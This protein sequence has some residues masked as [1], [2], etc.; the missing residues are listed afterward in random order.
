MDSLVEHKHQKMDVRFG[1]WNIRSLYRAGALKVVARELEMFKLDLV[2]I[3]EVRWEKSGTEQAEDYI[4]FYEEGNEDHQL[5]RGFFVHKKI[6]SAVRRVEFVSDRMSFK[7]LKGHWCN[8][9]V[10]NVHAAGMIMCAGGMHGR[11][12]KVYKVLVGNTEAKKPLVRPRHRSEDRIKID[13][14]EIG[15]EVWR[16]LT[17][18]RVQTGGE[19]L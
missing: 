16:G 3:Q 5:G 6:I 4:F 2:D 11:G 8:I 12:D 15:W 7:I 14:N 1:T 19:L 17:W 10:V 18:L 13:L 9:I